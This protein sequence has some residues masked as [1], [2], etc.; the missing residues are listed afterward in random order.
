[1][2]DSET[3][4]IEE[5]VHKSTVFKSNSSGSDRLNLYRSALNMLSHE[6]VTGKEALK[7][8]HVKTLSHFTRVIVKLASDK[9]TKIVFSLK[10]DPISSDEKPSYEQT[11]NHYFHFL[12]G[13]H[14][15]S[16]HQEVNV[17]LKDG[18]DTRMLSFSVK[19]GSRILLWNRDQTNQEIESFMVFG[20]RADVGHVSAGILLSHDSVLHSKDTLRSILQKHRHSHIS[21]HENKNHIF[22]CNDPW[23]EN[24]VQAL[25]RALQN[26]CKFP[27]KITANFLEVTEYCYHDNHSLLWHMFF[28]AKIYFVS[29]DDDLKSALVHEIKFDV[30]APKF[31]LVQTEYNIIL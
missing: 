5:D 23:I 16:G 14:L 11:L 3:A 17:Y 2:Q 8:L 13:V 25:R 18:N 22:V 19:E 15:D 29:V 26:N 1:M 10:P 12:N 6:M 31:N 28:P 9:Q 7:D 30:N 24:D 4:W 27:K 21:S 20:P